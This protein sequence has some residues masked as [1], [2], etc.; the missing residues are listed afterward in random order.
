MCRGIH[1]RSEHVRAK[2]ERRAGV[3]SLGTPEHERLGRN[4]ERQSIQS[5]RPRAVY[6]VCIVAIMTEKEL[7]HL[8][9]I[10]YHEKYM[11]AGFF[12]F[13]RKN[14]GMSMYDFIQWLKSRNE[15]L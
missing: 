4:M 14:T 5:E 1:R 6:R 8:L 10:Y 11:T 15:K 7:L 2:T 12:T 13:L 3:F 9:E